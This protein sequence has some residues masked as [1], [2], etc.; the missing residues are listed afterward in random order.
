[1]SSMRLRLVLL[2]VLVSPHLLFAD[3]IQLYMPQHKGWIESQTKGFAAEIVD[4]AL[5]NVSQKVNR[6]VLPVNRA[7]RYF[8]Q[9]RPSCFVGGDAKLASELGAGIVLQSKHFFE[10]SIRLYTSSERSAIGS[11]SELDRGTMI[12]MT[13]GM[14]PLITPELKSFR[15]VEYASIELAAEALRKHRISHIVHSSPLWSDQ[16]SGLQ[17]NQKLTLRQIKESI[18]C[19]QAK[20]TAEFIQSFNQGLKKVI[21]AKQ[22]ETVWSRY[23]DPADK[24]SI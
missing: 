16:V 22:Y 2:A 10:T 13:R 14:K 3:A 15:L 17:F 12:G 6:Q 24:P 4:L 21:D 20:S 5:K 11:L 9:N 1:M 8:G 7:A 18:I 19:H 23:F